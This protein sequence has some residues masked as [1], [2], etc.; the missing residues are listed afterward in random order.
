MC[1]SDLVEMFEHMRNWEAL[2]AKVAAALGRDGRFFLHIFTH[3]E[4][5]YAYDVHDASDWMAEH[6]FSGGIMPSDRMPYAFAGP[7]TVDQHWRVNG[8]HYARTAE[9]WLANMDAHAAEI[10]PIFAG[11]Y[12]AAAA[13]MWWQRWRVFFMACAELWAW[14]AGEEWLVSH[15]TMARD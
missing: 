15:Y 3:R 9:A 4:Y 6:F 11:T 7:L 8:T 12:G 13:D 1:S 5:A 2:F 14:R 10:R